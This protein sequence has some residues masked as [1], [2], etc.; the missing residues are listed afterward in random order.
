MTP[1]TRILAFASW[2]SYRHRRG[3]LTRIDSR[4][5]WVLLDGEQDEI[6]VSWG[7]IMRERESERALG[8]AE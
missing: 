5:P 1:G 6:A 3:T 8:G 2:S 4:G 7:E